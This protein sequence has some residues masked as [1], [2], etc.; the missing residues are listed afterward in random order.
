MFWT[1]VGALLFVVLILP[2]IMFVLW[3]IGII[4][5]VILEAFNS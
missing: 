3:F 2:L 1:I 4:I 5:S